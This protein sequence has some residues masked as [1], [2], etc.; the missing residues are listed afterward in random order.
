MNPKQEVFDSLLSQSIEQ[1]ASRGGLTAIE[2]EGEFV[3]EK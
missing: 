3:E 1:F 2:S